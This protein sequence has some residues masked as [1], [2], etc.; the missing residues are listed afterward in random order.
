M[1]FSMTKAQ[2]VTPLALVAGA[3]DTKGTV[4]MLGM[5][6]IKANAEGNLSF[7]CSD[8]GVV[9]RA[10]VPKCDVS[11][12]G[13]IAVDVRRF[14]DLVRAVP[15]QSQI[16]IRVDDKGL[17]LKAGRSRFKLPT[18]SAVDYPRMINEKAERISITMD[19]SRL[20][21]MVEDISLSMAVADVRTFLN[22][23]LFRIDQQGLWLVS[24]DG[25][26]LVVAHEPIPSTAD[27]TPREVIVPRKTVLLAKKFLNQ[28]A[29]K[30]TLGPSDFQ[31][32]LSDGTV[33]MGKSIDGQFCDWKRVIPTPTFS[34]HVKTDR[35]TDS[36]SMV[37]AILSAADKKDGSADSI[38]LLIAPNVLTI[39]KGDKARCEVDIESGSGDEAGVFLNISYLSDATAIMKTGK[40]AEVRIGYSST[41]T[42][43]ALTI[44]PKDRDYPLAVVMPMRG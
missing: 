17:Q 25:S 11:V 26:R 12:P 44:R 4:P 29:V 31:L 2:L 6:L 21:S 34:F 15:D 28:G 19:A 13:E 1:Q 5:V 18:L 42:P 23:A 16:D 14:S 39:Q 33:L 20:A 24:S 9:A 10:A 38:E 37:S 7:I 36:L 43:T 32:S 8:T 41:G 35:L 3:A 40:V 30:L 27:V 22:G